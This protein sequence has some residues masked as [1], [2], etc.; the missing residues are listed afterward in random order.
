MF[1]FA[2]VPLVV[3]IG[4]S[5]SCRLRT[6]RCRKR[7]STSCWRTRCAAGKIKIPPLMLATFVTYICICE[8]VGYLCARLDPLQDDGNVRR[9]GCFGRECPQVRLFAWPSRDD[10]SS[11]GYSSLS[12]RF[13]GRVC[14]SSS[15]R[16]RRAAGD[17]H[18]AN[19]FFFVL[20]RS[21]SPFR[22][23]LPCCDCCTV[24]HCSVMAMFFAGGRAGAG[25]VPQQG[26]PSQQGGRGPEG[27]GR[28]GGEKKGAR[29]P[30]ARGWRCRCTVS[31]CVPS[32]RGRR[33]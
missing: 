25:G 26:G 5:W 15:C 19:S 21:F 24:C 22:S 9:P 7:G 33:S 11:D 6:G 13:A 27:V 16:L 28:D 31:F 14:S 4:R 12:H 23:A 20:S 30:V 2:A 18:F 32:A 17:S 1:L 10:G 3:Q 29:F 8:C